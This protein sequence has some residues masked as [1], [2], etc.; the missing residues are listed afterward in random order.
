MTQ[1]RML[2]QCVAL[3]ALI[4]ATVSCGDVARSGQ[5]P[6][7][8]VLQRL[9]AKKGNGSAQFESFLQSDVITNVTSP[10]PCSTTNPCPTIFN[11]T[12]SATFSL[13]LKDITNASIAAPTTNN[14]VTISRYHVNYRRADGRNT[15]GVDVPYGFDGGMTATVSGSGTSSVGFELVRHAAK[16]EAPL[17]ALRSN[18]I[19]ITT[20]A[21]VTFYGTDQV[22][23][24]IQATGNI[25]VDFGNFGDQ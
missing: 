14:V 21:E 18:P 24:D 4:M 13:S 16:L 1:M 5:S 2:K 17:M 23:N 25:Q 20:I 19:V 15:P 8:L 12:G 10:A 7:Y 22:G 9:E 6:V 11:D 3:A